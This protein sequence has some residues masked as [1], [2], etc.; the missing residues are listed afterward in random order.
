MYMYI[1]TFDTLS[2]LALYSGD[3]YCPA[4]LVNVFIGAP[5]RVYPIKKRG[6]Y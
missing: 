6:T 3:S 4:P 5:F 1:K 2:I